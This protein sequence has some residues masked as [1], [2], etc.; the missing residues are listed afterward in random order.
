MFVATPTA[1]VLSLP[2]RREL[3]FAEYGD[4]DGLPVFGFHGTPGSRL[5]LA[6]VADAACRAGVR[7]VV[8]DR[9]GYGHSDFVPRRRLLDWPADVTAIADHLG[10]DRFAVVGV[11]GGGPHALACAYA[12]PDRLTGVT[13]VS[14]PSPLGFSNPTGD[15]T[16]GENAARLARMPALTL[17]ATAA[18]VALSRRFPET[19]L[20]VAGRWMPEPDLRVVLRPE[21]REWL[22]ATSPHMSSTTAKAAAQDIGLFVNDW[23]FPLPEVTAA[24]DVWHGTADR[25]VDPFHAHVLARSMPN[26]TLHMCE[27]EG[28]L[29][30]ADQ[31]EQIL[32]G[33]AQPV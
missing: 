33:V 8:P 12:V 11:S 18:L 19:M 17:P 4:L 22:L 32:H 5:Q 24:V 6:P 21:F 14:S 3:A 7:L 20:H 15:N 25:L 31:A 10:I 29:L 30:F 26:T 28:H 27:R 1:T 16:L 2:E 9:P 13:V 23:G